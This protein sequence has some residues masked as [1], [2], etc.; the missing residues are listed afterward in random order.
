MLLRP[1]TRLNISSKFYN[2]ENGFRKWKFEK[3]SVSNIKLD[4]VK[5]GGLSLNGESVFYARTIKFM[6]TVFP[7][8]FLPNS[9]YL[10]V[11]K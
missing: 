2:H 3:V 4:N 5:I 8:A 6:A 9:M 1:A 10:T 7:V 11:W